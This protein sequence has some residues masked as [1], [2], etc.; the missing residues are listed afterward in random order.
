LFEATLE[1]VLDLLVERRGFALSDADRASVTKVL[2]AFYESGPAI[3]YVYRGTAEWHPNYAQLMDMRDASGTNWSYLGSEERFQRV[4]GPKTLRAIGN[5][6]RGYG[7][8]VD[9]FYVSNV[10]P[11]LFADDAWRRF[12]DSVATLPLS[13]DAV[14]IRTFFGSTARQCRDPRP[15]IRTPVMGSMVELLDAYR[16]GEIATQCALVPLSR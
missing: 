15:P 14:F 1:S 6:V 16:S 13:R 11:Y 10:E 12:Y 9:V 2:T 5:Y 7:E 3:Q 4:R 8:T